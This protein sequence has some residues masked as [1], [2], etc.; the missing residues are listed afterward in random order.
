MKIISILGIASIS[1]SACFFAKT[2]TV[3][4]ATNI[5]DM[6]SIHS[7]SIPTLD[8]SGTLNMADYAGKKIMIVNVASKCG[9]TPQYAQLQSLSEKYKDKLVNIGCP[10]NQFGGQEPGTA[11]EIETFCQK[12]FGV[13]FPLSQKLDV[14]GSNQ[15]SLYQ[16]LTNKEKNGA[17]DADVSWNF[18][19]FL[20]D[21]EGKM[22]GFFPS[23]VK[24]DDEKITS[25][26]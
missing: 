3:A 13:T 20:L 8:E 22:I 18:C 26:L 12:N 17:L 15:S 25:L 11:A 21:E 16:W 5:Q 14:K 19:K 1:L 6:S 24:P 4:P 23:S 7:Y 10:C 9:Y 2:K